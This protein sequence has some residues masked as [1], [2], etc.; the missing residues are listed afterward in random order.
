MEMKK[1]M[2]SIQTKTMRIEMIYRRAMPRRV[3]STVATMMVIAESTTLPAM[4]NHQPAL[5]E[6]R[7]TSRERSTTS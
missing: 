1:T 3:R 5:M 2:K 4:L 7:I 6:S